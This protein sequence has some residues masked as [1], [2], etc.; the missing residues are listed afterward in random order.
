MK[1]IYYFV[2]LMLDDLLYFLVDTIHYFKI[3]YSLV[4]FLLTLYLFICIYYSHFIVKIMW[5][6]TFISTVVGLYLKNIDQ[7]FAWL[8]FFSWIAL[9]FITLIIGTITILYKLLVKP[10]KPLIYQR[11]LPMYR[12]PPVRYN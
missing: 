5:L 12:R 9:F 8:V 4:K 11:A 2:L 6:I 3:P 1:K 7:A 10:K